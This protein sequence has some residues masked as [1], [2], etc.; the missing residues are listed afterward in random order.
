MNADQTKNKR[1]SSLS[2]FALI[3]VHPRQSAA[4]IFSVL[5]SVVS[6]EKRY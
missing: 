3:R 6:T 5:R 1:E 4:N 2:R